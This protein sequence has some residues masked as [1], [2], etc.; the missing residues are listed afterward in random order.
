LAFAE[1]QQCYSG[2]EALGNGG[3][4]MEREVARSVL[5]MMFEYGGKLNDAMLMIREASDPEEFARYRRGIGN[6]LD[7]AFQQIIDPILEEHPDLRPATL[8]PEAPDSE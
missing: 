6:V 2:A 3:N 8:N 1:R 5:N 4:D 7:A